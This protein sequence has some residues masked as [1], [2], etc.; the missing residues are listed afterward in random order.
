MDK[1]HGIPALATTLNT[2][3]GKNKLLR[4]I[5]F[6]IYNHTGYDTHAISN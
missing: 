5:R 3:S 2:I 4:E 6:G 1:D